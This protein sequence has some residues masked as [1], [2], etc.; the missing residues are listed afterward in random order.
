MLA[1]WSS[2]LEN[3]S[4]Y[5]V[6]AVLTHIIVILRFLFDPIIR[7]TSQIETFDS[8]LQSP[9]VGLSNDVQTFQ[10]V[11]LFFILKHRELAI[12]TCFWDYIYTCIIKRLTILRIYTWYHRKN[13]RHQNET[14][15]SAIQSPTVELSN[16]HLI[17]EIKLLFSI[18]VSRRLVQVIRESEYLPII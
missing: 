13:S 9:H 4:N 2:L 7:T 3:L 6:S 12:K 1:V 17:L 8:V 16:E 15:D 14:F 18:L 11:F 10:I 5:P